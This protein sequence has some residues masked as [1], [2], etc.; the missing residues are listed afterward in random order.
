MSDLLDLALRAHGGL[1]RWRQATTIGA[2]A[3]VG[4]PAL[5]NRQQGDIFAGT[6]VTVDV[7]H[8]RVIVHNFAGTGLTGVYT[9]HRVA[10]EDADGTVRQELH[11]PRDSF[12]G[13]GPR[14]PWT[15]LQALYFGGYALW[16][17][18]TAPTT[19]PRCRGRSS[20]PSTSQK[21]ASPDPGAVRPGLLEGSGPVSGR[22]FSPLSSTPPRGVRLA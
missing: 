15:Q 1:D 13:F 17:Y 10:I 5:P 21:S 20:S 9:P 12:R 2:H 8:Q 19:T 3:I 16:N 7:Q 11:E 22:R 14:S 18:L 6:D 4:G